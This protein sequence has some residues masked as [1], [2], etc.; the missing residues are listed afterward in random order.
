MN[1][2]I[3]GA[4]GHG[5]VV[6]DI[7]LAG[8]KN[9]NSQAKP[10]GF[11]DDNPTLHQ[12]TFLELPVLGAVTQLSAIAHDAVIVAV[13][14]N[15]T[16]QQIFHTLHRQNEQFATAVHPTA[17][18]GAGV[19]I[20]AGTMIC[21]GVVVNPGT[22]LG[23]GVIL[24]TGC[25]VDHHNRLGDYVHIGPGAHLG[26][27]VEIEE[28]VLVGIGATV[29]PQ[30]RIGAWSVVGAGAVVTRDIPAYTIV[31][32]VPAR[33]IGRKSHLRKEHEKPQKFGD[34]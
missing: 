14:D 4:G 22:H 2:L 1:I 5:Q 21:A 28:G 17:V 3:I 32:G 12:Q 8:L 31:V 26:G 23:R 24:N 29:M 16:R 34:Y 27:D 9:N 18:I 30:R 19:K 7:F 25:T 11:L 13:G 15:H 6:A 33:A 10:V 20:G